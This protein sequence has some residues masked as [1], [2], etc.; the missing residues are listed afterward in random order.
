[1][2][3]LVDFL[4]ALLQAFSAHE[5]KSME[6][7]PKTFF[8]YFPISPMDE[9]WGLYATTAGYVKI[10]PGEAYP[11]PDHPKA[12]SLSWANGRILPEFQLHY[13]TR[14]GGVFESESAGRK[15][16]EA[17]NIFMLF[18]REWHRYRPRTATGWDEYWVGFGGQSATRLLRKGFLSPRTPVLRPRA[19]HALLDLF[20]DMFGEMRH[21]RLGFSQI[22]GATTGLML[23]ILHA[24][25][26]AKGNTD[27]H[28]E[29]A[30]RKAK[31]VLHE[32]LDRALDMEQVAGQLHVSYAWLRRHFRY[33][34][35]LP[36]HGYHLQLRVNRAMHLLSGSSAPVKEV[37]AQT[38]FEDAQYFSRLFKKKTGRTP[39][40]WR[41]Q[42]QSA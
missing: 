1:M 29:A 3:L 41:R 18:P 27:T 21:E 7:L 12:Y 4:R 8:R 13:I 14:G 24:A 32:R 17:G 40:D 10:A 30:I 33:H 39:E 42:Y 20:T 37:A 28:H 31:A 23:A 34:T 19:E 22:L 5:Q 9:A 35:G 25:A 38:G 11:P 36:L 26:R 16:I 15:Q 6:A 2:I